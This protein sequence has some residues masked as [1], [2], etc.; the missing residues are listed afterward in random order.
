MR[1]LFHVHGDW[2]STRGT[3]KEPCLD[4]EAA[5]T[6]LLGALINT[7]LG[8]DNSILAPAGA[9]VPGCHITFL[10]LAPRTSVAV[11]IAECFYGPRSVESGG[12]KGVLCTPN[13]VFVSMCLPSPLSF[14]CVVL[15]RF[16]LKCE[17]VSVQSRMDSRNSRHLSMRTPDSEKMA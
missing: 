15:C 4:L 5:V 13:G 10:Y 3:K 2:R 11:S 1:C 6:L 12:Q 7:P 14:F 17:N 8:Q 16:N 9:K